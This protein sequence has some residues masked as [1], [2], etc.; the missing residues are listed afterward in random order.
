MALRFFKK[1]DSSP[2]PAARSDAAFERDA[3][4]ARKFFEHAESMADRRSYDYAIKLYINGLRHDPDNMPK[5]EALR[6]VAM[7][8]KAS[9]GKPAGLKE[10]RFES[11]GKDPISKMLDA[12][13]IW[14]KD[15]GNVQ[16]MMDVME[17]AVE[18]DQALPVLHLGEFAQWVGKLALE[19]ARGQKK[20]G[21]NDYLHLRDLFAAVGA[22]EQAI[23]ACQLALSLKPND[24]NLL[25]E[26]KNLETQAHLHQDAFTNA[27]QAGGF[28]AM[29]KDMDKQV[30]LEQD[31]A[32]TRNVS[33]K[34][35]IIERRRGELA[36]EPDN[37]ERI[38]RLARALLDKGGDDLE[39]EALRL[40]KDGH[41]RTG[42]YRL[43]ITWSDLL[44]RQTQRRMRVLREKAEAGDAAAAEQLK[45]A[46]AKLLKFELQEFTERAAKYPTD[47]GIKFQLGKRLVQAGQH[48]DAIAVFQEARNDGKYRVQSLLY[49]GICYREQAW[50]DEAIETLRDGLE[51]HEIE[52][53]ATG[54]ELQYRLMDA[55]EASARESKDVEQAKEAQKIASKILRTDIRFR[56]IKQRMDAIRSLVSELGGA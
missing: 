37:V 56:D 23:T 48:D 19:F 1:D 5:H 36:E 28:R 15:V 18:A 4:K 11:L 25:Q 30:E 46:R 33:Q 17:R 26:L 52:D 9:G 51:R 20:T 54:L 16:A 41:E 32:I 27:G 29:V 40:L 44:I 13:K 35:Q 49:L 34:D 12:E 53:D 43:R 45:Q 22:F 14:A 39:A 7:R 3:A 42:D 50:Y 38:E 21:L 8:Y 47:M 10:R 6:D 24:P 55:L 2:D 31:S